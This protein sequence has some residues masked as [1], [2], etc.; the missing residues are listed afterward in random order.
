MRTFY[1]SNGPRI[2]G[3]YTDPVLD[4]MIDKQRSTFDITQRKSLVK[5]V[6][7]Y[8]IDHTPYTSWSSRYNPNAAQLKVQ[9]F[10]PEGNSAVW[11]SNYE[12]VWLRP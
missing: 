12:Q 9:G 10:A 8:M 1:Y 5:D 2:Y 6:L 7:T 4:Q 11:G 3:S